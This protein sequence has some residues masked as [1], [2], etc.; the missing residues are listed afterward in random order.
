MGIKSEFSRDDQ[1]EWQNPFYS[2]LDRCQAG[3]STFRYDLVN[4]YATLLFRDFDAIQE[5][6][7]SY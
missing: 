4:I 6:T 2:E 5:T 3:F 7:V 1:A